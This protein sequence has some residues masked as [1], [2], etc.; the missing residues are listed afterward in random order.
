MV[1]RVDYVSVSTLLEILV[2]SL[3]KRH[4]HLDVIPVSLKELASFNPS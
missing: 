1:R 3:P 4:V 2:N